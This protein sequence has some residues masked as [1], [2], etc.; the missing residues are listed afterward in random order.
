MGNKNSKTEK[1][2]SSDEV[3]DIR[4]IY[5]D[6]DGNLRYGKTYRN[7]EEEMV[8]M[9]QRD[10]ND[11]A[12]LSQL[13]M[14]IPSRWVRH[15]LLF[16]YIKVGQPPGPI[17]MWSLL[18]DDPSVPGGWRPTNTLLPPSTEF[19]N[20]HPGHYRRVTLEAWLGFVELYGVNGYAIAV[21]GVP[22]DDI[23][24]WRVF[25]DPKHIDINLLPEPELP[26][27]EKPEGMVDGV[28][29]ALT[30][31]FG[32]KGD[33]KDGK[34]QKDKGKGKDKGKAKGSK[35]AGSKKGGLFKNPF[36]SS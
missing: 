33:D 2:E 31:L 9:L 34:K 30:G 16:A 4:K 23:T 15:W 10:S 26:E 28:T 29:N 22:V 18:W 35:D 17:D 36:K 5:W 11:E 8:K 1:K 20:E 7:R 13:W 25:K 21:R 14:I 12:D 3:R 24:R 27:E 6:A 19:G 32:L